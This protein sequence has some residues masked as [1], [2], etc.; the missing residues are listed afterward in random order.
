M[1]SIAKNQPRYFWKELN[2]YS[3]NKR[4]LDTQNIDIKDLYTHS[5]DLLLTNDK[6]C[7]TQQTYHNHNVDQERDAEYTVNE[8]KNAVFH[9]NPNKACEICAKIY[10]TSF[11]HICPFLLKL[12]NIIFNRAEYP[13]D[14]G[15]SIITPKYK[16]GNINT[17]S[18]Y[19]GITLTNIPA[20]IYSQ[21]LLNGLNIWTDKHE[22]KITNCQFG[23]QK[24][25]ST[26]YRLYIYC[27]FYCL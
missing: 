1:S 11:N 22:K 19:R 17:A 2:K 23:F 15:T 20:N 8:I 5:R 25:K 7:P 13:R 21:I 14:W 10:K 26:I 18:N 16:G 12:Y 9:K 24:G 4:S 27:S 3:K 6:T